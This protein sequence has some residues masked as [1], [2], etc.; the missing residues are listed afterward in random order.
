[1]S[2]KYNFIS[3]QIAKGDQAQEKTTKDPNTITVFE[4]GETKTIDFE[5]LDGTRQN[6]HYSHYITSWM[7]KENGERIIKIFFATHLITL[8]GYCLDAIYEAL[9]QFKVKSIKANNSRYQDSLPD[10]HTF[11]TDIIIKW[12]SDEKI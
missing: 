3:L 10:E 8:K 9:R 5:L 11:V 7:G 6:F 1:M 12:K 4:T 2:Q